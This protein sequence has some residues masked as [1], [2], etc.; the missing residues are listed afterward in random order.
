MVISNASGILSPPESSPST[1]AANMTLE[2]DVGTTS[3]YDSG[4]IS[5]MKNVPNISLSSNS[6]VRA[7]ASFPQNFEGLL[8]FDIFC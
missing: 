1:P 6:S 8:V 3:V 2:S 7:D 4:M 5:V